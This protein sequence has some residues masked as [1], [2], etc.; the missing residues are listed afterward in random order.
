M[1]KI[2]KQLESGQVELISPAMFEE[3]V[4]QGDLPASQENLHLLGHHV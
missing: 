4:G 2:L 1:F 3:S